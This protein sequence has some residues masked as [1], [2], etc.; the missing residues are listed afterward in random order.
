MVTSSFFLF[1]QCLCTSC[2][3][4]C[5]EVQALSEFLELDS[6]DIYHRKCLIG[7]LQGS[8]KRRCRI[9]RRQN[10]YAG[11]DRDTADQEAVAVLLWPRVGVSI[12]RSRR[13]SRSRSSTL[14]DS[15]SNLF[16]LIA[17]IPADFRASAVRCVA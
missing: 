12:T 14:G 17:L 1:V 3:Q 4:A 2:K 16:T 6:C 10:M 15:C 5:P 11:L 13:C 9:E 8:G 7:V